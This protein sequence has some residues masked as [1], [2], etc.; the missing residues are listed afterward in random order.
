MFSG[1]NP[2]SNDAISREQLGYLADQDTDSLNDDCDEDLPSHLRYPEEDLADDYGPV[3]PSQS[4]NMYT[5]E[6][7]LTRDT[8]VRSHPSFNR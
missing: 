2:K 1:T 5:I 8:G 6:D 3:P 4:G 7:P